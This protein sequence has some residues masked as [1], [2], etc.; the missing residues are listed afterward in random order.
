[1]NAALDDHVSFTAL[2]VVFS[3]DDKYILVATDR[4]RLILYHIGNS[5][6]VSPS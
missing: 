6:P 4:D 3:P 5:T 2:D 1:M